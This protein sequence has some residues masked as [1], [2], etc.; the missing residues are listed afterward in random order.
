METQWPLIIFT[1]FVCL[2]C[3]LLGAISILALRGKGEKL[4]LPALVVSFVSLVLGGVASFLHLQHWERAFNG[5]GHLTSGI[6][7]EMI[8]CVALVIIMVLWFI[9]L[10]G[11]K[12]VSKV[13]AGITLVV[14][15]LMIFATAHSYYM[16][17]RPAWGLSLVA[18]YLGN[19]C[20]LGA[21]FLWLLAVIRRDEAIEAA[22]AKMVIVG[23][24]AQLVGDGIFVAFCAPA[25][26]ADFGYYLDPTRMTL[27]PTHIDSLVS[28][29]FTGDGAFAFWGSIV[30]VIVALSC[31]IAARRKTMA[32]GVLMGTAL[33]VA[34]TT[35]ILFRVLIY[36]VGY[37]VFL[38]Y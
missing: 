25:K 7:Q 35:S 22:G 33:L 19:A 28:Y 13:L 18:F 5:F 38:L 29:I 2:T 1:L 21:I 30:C 16:A 3:G 27:A 31:A 10:R 15:L 20:L 12:P 36:M 26:L 9:V 23:A 14:A 8:G 32:S 34:V 24:L 11:K 4:Q 6:T 37:P 17:A